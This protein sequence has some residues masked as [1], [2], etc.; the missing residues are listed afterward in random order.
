MRRFSSIGKCIVAWMLVMSIAL[1]LNVVSA[2]A[3]EDV[4][5]DE[6]REVEK[7][8]SIDENEII[9]FDSE[10]AKKKNVSDTCIDSIEANINWMNQLVNEKNAHVNQ[11]FSVTIYL[12]STRANGVNKVVVHWYGLVQAYMDSVETGKFI[13]QLEGTHGVISDWNGIFGG[14]FS[15][16]M[17]VGLKVNI[18]AVKAAAKSGRGIIMNQ[19]YDAVTQLY[20]V[21]FV[22]Q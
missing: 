19:Q 10:N 9:V 6:L 21:W 3:E 13:R 20:N 1:N 22:S 2:F 15:G 8:L 5:N 14:A 7:Y 16:I 4:R 11:D 17:Q 18:S 12:K